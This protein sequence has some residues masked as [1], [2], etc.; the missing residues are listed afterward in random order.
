MHPNPVYIK[1]LLDQMVDEYN[2]LEFIPDDPVS[3]PHRFHVKEDIEIAGF[4][5]ATISWGQRKTI[6]KNALTLMQLMDHA[7]FQFIQDHSEKDLD[8]FKLFTHRTFNAEDCIF[9]IRSLRNI[10][11]V[12]G[13]MESLFQTPEGT[14][15]KEGMMAFRRKFFSVP[16][17]PRSS[18]HIADP[19][20]GASAKRINMFLRWMVRKDDCGVDF[21]IWNSIRPSQLYCPLD[22][23]TG[24]SARHLGILNI[25]Q[26]NWKAVEELTSYLRKLDPQDPVKY[27]Y[28]LFGMGLNRNFEF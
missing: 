4:L 19:S 27:D 5:T 14:D 6:L 8:R 21:G 15:L 18:K 13:G 3:I 9:F 28:A 22:V 1:N 20:K 11:K 16:Y 23:H 7:P 10:Y 24:N 2:R 12:Y 17:S 25:R 26:D